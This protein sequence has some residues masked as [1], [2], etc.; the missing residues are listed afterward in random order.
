VVITPLE[1][2]APEDER[3]K[4]TNTLPYQVAGKIPALRISKTVGSG[5]KKPL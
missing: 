5:L 2:G 4:C 3:S 1:R